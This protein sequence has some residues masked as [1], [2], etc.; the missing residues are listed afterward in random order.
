MR[1]ITTLS[2]ENIFCLLKKLVLLWIFPTVSQPELFNGASGSFLVHH[3]E[4]NKAQT[5]GKIFKYFLAQGIE[6]SILT[7]RILT[8]H[9]LGTAYEVEEHHKGESV[10][11][12]KGSSGK[13]QL[14][15]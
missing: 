6:A 8:N 1:C 14:R 13:R 9:F 4:D 2:Q 12:N 5:L 15:I 7:S 10:S 3:S 11:D